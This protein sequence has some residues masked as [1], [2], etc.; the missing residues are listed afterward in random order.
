MQ[1]TTRMVPHMPM[2]DTYSVKMLL[3]ARHTVVIPAADLFLGAHIP[4]Q[5]FLGSANCLLD[6]LGK[7]P[8]VPGCWAYSR[9]WRFDPGPA[10]H[11]RGCGGEAA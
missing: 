1:T 5:H 3:P 2:Q 8:R 10:M 6:H 9:C 11:G 7:V 4:V